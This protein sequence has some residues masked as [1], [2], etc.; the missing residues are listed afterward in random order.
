MKKMNVA[1]YEEAVKR[2]RDAQ[3]QVQK[4]RTTIPGKWLAQWGG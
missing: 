4:L 1:P 3:I 2:Y